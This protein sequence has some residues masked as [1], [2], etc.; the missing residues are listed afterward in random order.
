MNPENLTM[1]DIARA[2]AYDFATKNER[3]FKDL[4][5]EGA[6][7][8]AILK[9]AYQQGYIDGFKLRLTGEQE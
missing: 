6:S 9:V 8:H 3:A 4:R 5:D 7:L 1:L 2:R